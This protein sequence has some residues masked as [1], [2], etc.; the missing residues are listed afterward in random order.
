MIAREVCQLLPTVWVW[1]RCTVLLLLLSLIVIVERRGLA[2]RGGAGDE[3]RGAMALPGR[4]G[5]PEL[6]ISRFWFTNLSVVFCIS[7]LVCAGFG[8]PSRLTG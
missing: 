8:A 4:F 6:N 1:R 2:A 3:E 5:P 7:R